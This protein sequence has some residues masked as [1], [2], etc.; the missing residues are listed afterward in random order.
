MNKSFAL[1]PRKWSNGTGRSRRWYLWDYGLLRIFSVA[2]PMRISWNSMSPAIKLYVNLGGNQ[3][4]DFSKPKLFRVRNI[5]TVR[6]ILYKILAAS[7]RWRWQY[8][9]IISYRRMFVIVVIR[10]GCLW[11]IL[12]QLIP[13]YD[14]SPERA[15]ALCHN[16][17]NKMHNNCC[18]F[19]SLCGFLFNSWYWGHDFIKICHKNMSFV[20]H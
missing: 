16:N 2:F 14:Y 4:R 8:D 13:R 3:P 19:F 10:V 15:T 7:R 18:Y 20:E 6:R 5:F 9:M 1:R 17:V 11:F 12:L